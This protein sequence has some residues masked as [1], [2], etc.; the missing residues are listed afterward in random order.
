MNRDVSRSHGEHQALSGSL[1]LE[2]PR[3][4]DGPSVSWGGHMRGQG[5][6][7][8]RRQPSLP[9]QDHPPGWACGPPDLR[10][11]LLD[12][13]S[14]RR[15]HTALPGGFVLLWDVLVCV[16]ICVLCVCIMC[17]RVYE[18]HVYVRRCECVYLHVVCDICI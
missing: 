4:G 1:K 14:L 13:G 10:A 9:A 2:Q 8:R 17:A 18:W 3:K 16:G 7:P 6:S 15:K 5:P 11:F 12:W